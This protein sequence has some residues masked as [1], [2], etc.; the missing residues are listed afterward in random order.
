[1]THSSSVPLTMPCSTRG[2]QQHLPP[3]P[4]ASLWRPGKA[5]LLTLPMRTE[6]SRATRA[7][8]THARNVDIGCG[9]G[10]RLPSIKCSCRTLSHLLAEVARAK[11]TP[12]AT[13]GNAPQRTAGTIE[14]RM[15]WQCGPTV[16]TCPLP[17]RATSRELRTFISHVE[18]TN[19]QSAPRQCTRLRSG[20]TPVSLAVACCRAANIGDPPS[21]LPTRGRYN[22]LGR[23][24]PLRDRLNWS[25]GIFQLPSSAAQL[26]MG[27]M[28]KLT[29]CTQYIH[30]A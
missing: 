4:L 26:Q 2:Q 22:Y 15:P 28:L 29:A 30:Y 17:S 5:V 27:P 24:I 18:V 20:P 12:W 25:P 23:T 1:M 7:S 8:C 10:L 11:P 3:V 13:R 14:S 9:C 16:P 19:A 21:P 6:L